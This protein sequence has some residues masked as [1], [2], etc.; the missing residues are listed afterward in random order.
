[1]SIQ[2]IV[3]QPTSLCNIDCGYCYLRDRKENFKMSVRVAEQVAKNLSVNED[4][5]LLI[6]HGGEPL[7]SGVSHFRSL[8]TPFEVLRNSEKVIH[9]VQTNGTLINASWCE[10]FKEFDVH[11]GV[12]IDGPIWANYNRVTFG[13]Q[14]TFTKTMKGIQWLRDQGIP[15]SVVCVVT[16]ETV[17]HAQELYDFFVVLGCHEVGFNLEEK[18]G[19]HIGNVAQ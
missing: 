13:K 1:M 19:I 17:E 14:E 5:A 6:W 10:F 4:P 11:V 8:L 16:E 2:R 18:I 3:M 15:F 7:A 9:S 12:S